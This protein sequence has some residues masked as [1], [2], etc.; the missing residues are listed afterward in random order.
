MTDIFVSLQGGQR[1]LTV[2]F[3]QGGQLKDMFGGIVPA[4]KALA[5]SVMGLITPYT[6]AAGVLAAFAVAAYEG[7]Q[8]SEALRKAL[9]TTGNSAGVS[10][11]QLQDNARAI[12]ALSGVTTGAAIDAMT[13]AAA[14]GQLMGE[15]LFYAAKG[16]A[17]WEEATGTAV[18]DT[19]AEYVELSKDPVKEI[20]KLDQTHHFLTISLYDQIKALQ[21]HGQS[22]RASVVAMRAYTDSMDSGLQK[23]VQNMGFLEG[24]LHSVKESF[25]KAFD[26]MKDFGRDD[27][28]SDKIQLTTA[29][30]AQ[31]N[32]TLATTSNASAR[33]YMTQ[34]VKEEQEALRAL[35]GESARIQEQEKRSADRVSVT[36]Y[37]TKGREYIDNNLSLEKKREQEIATEMRAYANALSA[38]QR[39]GDR[40]QVERITKLHA[41]V[42]STIKE[43][44]KDK[45]DGIAESMRQAT[46]QGYK[47]QLE[48]AQAKNAEETKIVEASYKNREITADAYYS[49]LKQ[50]R[51]ESAHN[52][53]VYIQQEINYLKA[54]H[55]SGKE[56][57]D[58]AKEIGKL[59]TELAN[60]R[61]SAHAEQ[62]KMD[63]EHSRALAEQTYQIQSYQHALDARSNALRAEL[64]DAVDRVQLGERE[65]EIQKKINA[66][67]AS[68]LEEKDKLTKQRDSK[69]ISPAVYDADSK[70]LEQH[71]TQDVKDVRTG[72]NNVFEAQKDPYTALKVSLADYVEQTADSA[73]H[74]RTL[75]SDAFSGAEDAFVK[76]IQ[77]G[78]L[79]FKDLAN[80]IISD[81]A[82]MAVKNMISSA[83]SSMMGMFG[84]AAAGASGAATTPMSVSQQGNPAGLFGGVSYNAK[85]N[86]FDAAGLHSYVNTVV[87]KPTVFPFAKGIGIMGEAGPEAIMPLR[88]VSGNRLGVEAVLPKTQEQP[89]QKHNITITTVVNGLVDMRTQDQIYAKQA[90]DLSRALMRNGL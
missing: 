71:H 39:L 62:Q 50:L 81:L 29:H 70:E 76:F 36:G 75:L 77:T 64:Q 43:K 48:I 49:R 51:S 2:L 59:E 26:V 89:R 20:L 22:L 9:I 68:Y 24:G 60:K 15:Q 66:L 87:S 73:Q 31:L 30:I 63:K 8:Q 58:T 56:A 32:E 4:A 6:V 10:A 23:I 72:Y 85:G 86:V 83:F 79:S 61:L 25:K 88:R 28:L 42:L 53:A 35:R 44:N 54:Q 33:A 13:Q 16:A 1:P 18:K 78:K 21:D 90:R 82:R 52:E 57:I 34:H 3:Q 40:E 27:T 5:S 41:D 74:V 7:A 37:Y 11:D 14:S 38:A 12:A 69:T 46:L 47:N 80:S 45:N 65:Y 84:G 17:A 55:L 67:H 19:I